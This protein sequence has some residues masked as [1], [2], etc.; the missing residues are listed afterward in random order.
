MDTGQ[1]LL[2]AK[3]VGLSSAGIFAGM[4]CCGNALSLGFS[5]YHVGKEHVCAGAYKGEACHFVLS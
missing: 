5:M 3:V 4:S 2:L 1:I